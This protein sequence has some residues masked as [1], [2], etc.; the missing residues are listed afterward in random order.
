MGLEEP[1]ILVL[2]LAFKILSYC[3]ESP[4]YYCCLVQFYIL[5]LKMPVTKINGNAS[6]TNITDRNGTVSCKCFELTP[7]YFISPSG[8]VG[9]VWN[10]NKI[11][12]N[13]SFCFRIRC[14]S[15]F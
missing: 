5:I 8:G 4:L 10:K 12:L 9:S 1:G 13:N 14:L 2:N 6:S 11:D 15:R 7:N 3:L